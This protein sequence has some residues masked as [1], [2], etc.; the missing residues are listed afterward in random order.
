MR[1][2]FKILL[3]YMLMFSHPQSVSISSTFRPIKK[4]QLK[5]KHS[6]KLYRKTN[7]FAPQFE[8]LENY[9]WSTQNKIKK[10]FSFNLDQ[11][12]TKSPLKTFSKII[13]DFFNWTHFLSNRRS[14][15]LISAKSKKQRQFFK[16]TQQAR[17][18][19]VIIDH[20]N[21][22]AFYRINPEIL[23]KERYA[24]NENHQ[25]QPYEQTIHWEFTDDN[26]IYKVVWKIQI[27]KIS[28]Y[29][30]ELEAPDSV[31]PHRKIINSF[32]LESLQST[33]K[34]TSNY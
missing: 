5:A 31:Y 7:R 9:T 27:E 20:A 22:L 6:L 17:F 12:P 32:N 26:Q 29:P 3:I 34:P 18:K 10:H 8:I 4:N 28:Y 30:F 16:G 23:I 14:Y 15:Q 33:R 25:L 24:S 1:I 19:S 11:V 2:S 21:Q 13:F